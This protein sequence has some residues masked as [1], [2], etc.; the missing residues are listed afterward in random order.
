MSSSMA[1]CSTSSSSSLPSSSLRFFSARSVVSL[2]S[3]SSF[4]TVSWSWTSN[5]MAFMVAP[6][7]F[8]IRVLRHSLAE[9][10]LLR[11]VQSRGRAVASISGNAEIRN[12][13]GSWP[14]RSKARDRLGIPSRHRASGAGVAQG[15]DPVVVTEHA[16][17]LALDHLVDLRRQRFSSA[18]W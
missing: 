12:E 7:R 11:R 4:F 8:V 14:S 2:S 17:V 13:R 10:A 5:S 9:R 18:A 16:L 1:V 15:A 3:L 6:H